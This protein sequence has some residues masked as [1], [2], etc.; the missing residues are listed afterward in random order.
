[1]NKK[2]SHF[3]GKEAL[4][5]VIEARQKGRDFMQKEHG[6]ELSGPFFSA[7]DA[8]KETAFFFTLLVII[9]AQFSITL[10]VAF[11]TVFALGYLFFRTGK[12]AIM[13]W[14]R[15]ERLHRIIEEERYEIEHHRPQEK[16]ELTALYQAKGFSGKLLEEVIEI[17]MADDNRLLQVMLEEELGLG[18]EKI[19]HPL[20]Q[21]LGAFIGALLS[22]VL[23]LVLISLAPPL[24]SVV[25]T[26][27]T[28][29]LCTSIGA[30]KEKRKILAAISWNLAV[31]FLSFAV[32]FFSCELLKGTF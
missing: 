19:E 17:L 20:K 5:H 8:A 26:A 1:M 11:F 31:I 15:L 9:Y 29:I 21:A 25:L 2:H 23:F 14:V 12:T 27:G 6:L 13:G 7:L 30:Y 28:I 16:E 32:A 18:L 22:S 4:S 24:Y 3:Q 10:P